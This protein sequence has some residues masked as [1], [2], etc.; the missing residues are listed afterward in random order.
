LQVL[1]GGIAVEKQGQYLTPFQRK[2]LQKSLQADLRPE[3]R[4][5]IE[6]MLLADIG[7]SQ[8]QICEALGCSPEMARYW[9][10]MAQTGNAHHWSDRPMGRPKT[11]NEQ[12]LNR[13]KELVSHS[14]REYGYPFQRWTAQWL[15]KH[16]AKELGIKLSN[17][18]I[19]R[20]LKQMGLSTRPKPAT[21]EAA[22]NQTSTGNSNLTIDDLT[23]TSVPESTQFWLFNSIR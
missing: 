15:G 1:P 3:Y 18:H 11:V 6:I 8:T 14:P 21:D 22:T 13:L 19:N 7:Q 2:L 9:I 16:L 4:R 10:V 20:L 5:R 23:S 12:Y 17:C